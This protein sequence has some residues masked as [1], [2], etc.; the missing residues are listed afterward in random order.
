M[1]RRDF[2][3]SAAA[4]AAL[5]P[6]AALAETVPPEGYDVADFSYGFVFSPRRW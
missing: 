5:L 1:R 2:L 6:A 4:V 3:S